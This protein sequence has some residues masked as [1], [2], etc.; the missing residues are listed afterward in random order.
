M[1]LFRK[2]SSQSSISAVQT[3]RTTPGANSLS[4]IL[5][6]CGCDTEHRLYRSLVESVPLIA[7]A[8]DKTVRLVGSFEVKHKNS[9]AQRRLDSFLRNVRVGA[10]QRGI[11]SFI[12]CYLTQ[13][14]VYGTAVGEIVPY[15]DASGIAALYNASLSDVELRQGDS[16]L[17]LKI[18]AR[19]VGE[20]VPV[21]NSGLILHTAL[22]PEPGRAY[23]TS[24][25]R[26]LPFVSDILLKIF[27]TIG[28]NWE[29]V[30]NVR[31]SVSCK[32]DGSNAKE[33]AKQIAEQWS[34]AMGDKNSTRDFVSVGDVDIKVI[35]ADN[36]ILDS[37]VPVRQLL[38]QIVA[39]LSIP[40]FLLGLNW[41]STERMA[42]QQCDILTS[43]LEWYRGILNPVIEKICR[44]CLCMN[45]D[46]EEIEIVW[47]NINLQDETEL[48]QSRLWTAQAR[49]IEQ[50]LEE[51]K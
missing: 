32:S 40:P 15:S 6:C 5:S 27:N 20:S 26:G 51:V 1:K 30:G 49:Q 21:K 8:I 10:A 35:G 14:L 31:F 23:G 18:Y 48:A 28:T 29:R 44:I 9:A 37:E 2:K 41:S 39:K 47:N 3:A 38:E 24:A 25:L 12:S 16:P 43:E 11:S 7:G 13:L 19:G 36:Q 50:S 46:E 22:N 45:G 17:E 4:S 42:Q 33:R 34:L